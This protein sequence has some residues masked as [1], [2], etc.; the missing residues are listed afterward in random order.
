[1]TEF[2]N[3]RLHTS[4][5]QVHDRLSSAKGVAAITRADPRTVPRELSRVRKDRSLAAQARRAAASITANI[6]EG[7]SGPSV[8]D[9]LS[10]VI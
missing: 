10:S 9:I 1:M 8:S 3:L 5:S 7:C 2:R 6:V 4:D